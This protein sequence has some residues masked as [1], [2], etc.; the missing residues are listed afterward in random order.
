MLI[1]LG[2]A[3]L[4]GL[5]VFYMGVLAG[6]GSRSAE[7]PV[8]AESSARQIGEGRGHPTD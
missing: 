4:T 6:K 8:P 1:S 7:P 5:V 2:L 3:L